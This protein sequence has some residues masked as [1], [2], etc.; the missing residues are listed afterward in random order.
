MTVSLAVPIWPGAR[1]RLAVSRTEGVLKSVTF[2]SLTTARLKVLAE[3][4]D[5]S[6]F[7]T[8]TV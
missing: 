3:Q 4:A 8:F 1:F 7:F 6:A 5:E 2:E